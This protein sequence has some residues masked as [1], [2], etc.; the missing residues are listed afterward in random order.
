[1]QISRHNISIILGICF[2]LASI[3]WMAF[4][5]TLH[6]DFF[7]YDDNRYVYENPEIAAGLTLHRI[8]W[9]F[10]YVH[11]GN[12]HPLTWI[13]H[14]LDC[15]LFGLKAGGHHFT[16]VLLHTSAAILLFLALREMTGAL[17]RS[18]FVAAVFAIHPL[19]VESVA[20]ISERKDVLS[21]VFFML[22]LLAYARYVSGQRSVFR[23]LLVV[24]FFALGLMAKP[25]LVTLPCVLL[26]L[27]YWPLRRFGRHSLGNNVT[28]ARRQTFSQ[29]VAEKIPVFLMSIGS[30][31]TTLWA[32]RE[33]MR[34]ELPLFTRIENALVSYARYLGQL[35]WPVDLAPFYPHPREALPLS[36][37]IAAALLLIMISAV[38]LRFGRKLPYLITGW[39]WYV[40]MLVP[41]IGLVQVGAQALADRYTYLPQIGI[42][43]GL[44][45]TIV[46]VT[47]GSR[48]WQRLAALAAV[49]LT[50]ALTWRAHDQTRY[51]RNSEALWLHTLAVTKNNDL[52]H[53]SLGHT[54]G[55]Q[56]RLDSAI[57]EF[58]AALKIAPES[59]AARYNLA[60]THIKKGEVGEAIREF[61]RALS[62]DPKNVQCRTSLAAALQDAGRTAE[63][64]LE[65]QRALELE[66]GSAER[67]YDLGN[68]YLLAGRPA[69]AIA[70]YKIA[71]QVRPGY[72]NAEYS[73]G[74]AEMQN[75][76]RP[77][78]IRRFE[79]AV[80]LAPNNPVAHNNLAV[81]L[82][83]DGRDD[84]AIPHLER[85]L[86]LQPS[87]A[88]AHN[89]L[90][91]ALA[92]KQKWNAAIGHWRKSLQI[93]PRNTEAQTCL[94]WTLATAPDSTVRNGAEALAL[95]R[96]LSQTTK[97]PDPMLFRVLAAAYAEAGQFAAAIET[98]RRGI[99]RATAQNRAELAVNL[100]ADLELFKSGQPL[101]DTSK[102][103]AAR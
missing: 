19:R 73:L 100:Q 78:A 43:L 21:G 67:H 83:M 24:F 101:R 2:C 36:L 70:Q 99:D 86:T 4:G 58:Q 38:V 18:A 77:E 103:P 102:L 56:G 55:R 88:G 92:G 74:A 87:N 23:Y 12:W 80:A 33:S 91:Q 71:L 47:A 57:G 72:A 41:V 34:L 65:Y 50:L 85:C 28:F 22:T 5:Q 45:W 35:F 17:W 14:M 6:H 90:A 48:L 94:A 3:T 69:E 75:G 59:F 8:P 13:S 15:R 40:I 42:V 66:P 20:W 79:N 60:V 11:S 51:W 82:L 53:N 89:N 81:A 7:N 54:W 39:G 49:V 31:F 46:E 26:L 84:E 32:Q 93:D 76:N 10:T 95:A 29:L 30:C 97:A 37:A 27:D 25:M 1:M 52:A 62:Y 64:V 16:N 96:H 98:A 61:E 44:T 9:A 68:A 63:A